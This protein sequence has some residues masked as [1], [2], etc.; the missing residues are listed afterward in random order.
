MKPSQNV[1]APPPSSYLTKWHFLM[2]KV[3]LQLLGPALAKVPK[4]LNEIMV[5]VTLPVIPLLKESHAAQEEKAV[6][7]SQGYFT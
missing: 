6:I 3:L 2:E 7:W 4:A 1:L 5:F